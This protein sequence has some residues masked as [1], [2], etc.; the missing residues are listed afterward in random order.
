MMFGFNFY[1]KKKLIHHLYQFRRYLKFTEGVW[2][3]YSY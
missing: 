2:N 3:V 1:Y